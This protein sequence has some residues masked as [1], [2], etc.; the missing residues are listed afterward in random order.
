LKK[1]LVAGLGNIG[2]EYAE[3]RHNIG[4]KV[5]DYL[6]EKSG[7]FFSNKRYA[8]VTEYKLKGRTL[9]LIKP[10]TYMNLSGKAI[11]FWLQEEKIPLENLLVV[12]DD[13]ALPYGSLRLKTKG[14]DGGHNGLKNINQV[15]G[16]QDYAR[17]RFGVDGNFSKGRQVEYVLGEWNEE[18]RLHLAKHIEK[19]GK[20]IESFALA[21]ANLTMNQ[22]N[23]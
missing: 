19:T 9:V 15:L 20:A 21:G 13:I 3:T 16:R 11:N 8:D 5:L 14:S 18:E 2:A 10:T 22:F 23:G 1:F 6:A 4:F 7:T 12:L 17:L